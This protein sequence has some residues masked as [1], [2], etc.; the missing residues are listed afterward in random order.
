MAVDWESAK[1]EK[2]AERLAPRSVDWKAERW[3]A[4]RVSATAASLADNWDAQKA[5]RR[6][7]CLVGL[8]AACSVAL[9]AVSWVVLTAL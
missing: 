4:W 8:T 1:A 5:A 2:T 7:V 6:V 3:V 9:R